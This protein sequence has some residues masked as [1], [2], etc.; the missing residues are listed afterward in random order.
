M[1]RRHRLAPWR[2]SWPAAPGS[3]PDRLRLGAVTLYSATLA[4]YTADQLH[5]IEEAV[6]MLAAALSSNLE[7]ALPEIGERAA[8][9]AEEEASPSM[10]LAVALVESEFKN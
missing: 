5:L 6:A 9:K 3:A 1:N 2:R 10:N 7:A 4:V 8:S